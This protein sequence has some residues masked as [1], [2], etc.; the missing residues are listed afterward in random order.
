MSSSLSSKLMD[1]D[2]RR[3]MQIKNR[4][5]HFKTEENQKVMLKANRYLISNDQ[6]VNLSTN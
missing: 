2:Y 3:S 1:R 5:M 6:S 4:L